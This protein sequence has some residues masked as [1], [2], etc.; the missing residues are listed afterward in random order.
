MRIFNLTLLI[1][2]MSF[3]A[4]NDFLTE[5]KKFERVREAIDEKQ[6]ILVERLKEVNLTIDNV[7]ILLVA[8][9]DEDVLELWVRNKSDEAFQKLNTYP[10]CAR[11]GF[12]GPKR[13]RGDNQVP[14]GYYYVD[15]F[16]PKS[17]FHLSLGLNYPN[18]SD[19]IKAI[20]RDPGGD[21]FIHGDCVTIGCLPMTDDKIKEIYSYAVFAKNNGQQHIPVYI[22][23][24]RMNDQNMISYR[25]QYKSHPGLLEFWAGLKPG[26]DRFEKDRMELQVQIDDRGVYKF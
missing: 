18:K 12:L 15:R 3:S 5:Q 7:H 25:E 8:Y 26:F 14:E 9:K 4:C 20:T 11:S 24:F 6:S 16:N 21:I 17:N 2:A 13:K 1:V 10:V 23:P 19:L 22:F